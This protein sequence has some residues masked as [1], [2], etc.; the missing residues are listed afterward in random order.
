MKGPRET[1]A[2]DDNAA[3]EEAAATHQPTPLDIYALPDK[4]VSNLK[5]KNLL[6]AACP[7]DEPTQ[8]QEN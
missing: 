5:K 6:P 1:D 2:P 7:G 8:G 4:V 3:G